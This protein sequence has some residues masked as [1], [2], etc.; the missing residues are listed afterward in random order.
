MAKKVVR[1]ALLLL[2]TN[3]L[4]AVTE[5]SSVSAS[6]AT[7][8]T[9]QFAFDDTV[10]ASTGSATLTP[11][12]L[13]GSAPCLTTRSYGVDSGDK[14]WSWT[15][16][17]GG[18]LLVGNY[19]FTDTYT[20][21]MEFSVATMSSYT[22]VFNFNEGDIGVY[23]LSNKLIYYNYS[24]S[25]V[26]TYSP[27]EKIKIVFTRD[28]SFITMYASSTSN[29][30]MTQQFQIA[31]NGR[32]IIRTLP[33]FYL[34]NDDGGENAT[35]GKIYSLSMWSDRALNLTDAR[36]FQF[37]ALSPTFSMDTLSG[38]AIYRVATTITATSN[39]PGKITFYL[40]GKKIPGCISLA[41]SGSAGS[42]SAQCSWRPAL[43]GSATISA[44]L[45]PTDNAYSALSTTKSIPV[46]KRTNQR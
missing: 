10:T 23:F 7:T 45:N 27:N 40:S 17:N 38:D 13:C 30:T 18:G 2:V 14:Y 16:S 31:S 4:L 8:P 29:P 36:N 24:T 6:T 41:T 25:S 19:S 43:H 37:Q 26:D 21:L 34:F 5:S 12:P 15:T 32:G 28:S 9:Y 35:G 22:R 44:K 33:T 1:I 20:I 3:L 39:L 42:Y 11:S 46:S